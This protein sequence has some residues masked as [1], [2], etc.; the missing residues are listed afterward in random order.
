MK[1]IMMALAVMCACAATA[2][3]AEA[4][5]PLKKIKATRTITLGYSETAVPF[6]FVGNDNRPQGYSVDLCK[7]IADGIQQQLGLTELKINWVKVDVATRILA[8]VK[9]TVDIE[10]GST[11]HTLSREEQ[12]DFS[13]MTFVDGGSFISKAR[14]KLATIKELS[15]RKISVIPGTTTEKVLKTALDQAQVRAEIIPVQTH[16]EGF[17][18]LREDRVDAYA[19]DRMILIGLALNAIDAQSYRL[20]DEMFSYEPYALMMRRDADFRLA[21][22]R[23]LARLYRSGDILNLYARWYGPLGEPSTLL[24]AMYFLNALPE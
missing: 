7:R 10:C 3:A 12:V 20:S 18:S 15:G 22:N 8:T 2:L 16:A 11:T 1:K 21:V 19:S 14:N 23:E 5:D 6:S 9:G 4:P 24:K 17:S 13:N